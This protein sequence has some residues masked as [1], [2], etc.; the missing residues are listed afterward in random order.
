MEKKMIEIELLSYNDIIKTVSNREGLV[1]CGTGGDLQ[2]WVTGV[3][4]YLY[5]KKAILS[6]NPGDI[7]DRVVVFDTTSAKLKRTDMLFLFQESGKN[8][9]I[10]KL[11]IVRL[12]MNDEITRT[13]WLSDYINNFA[14]DHR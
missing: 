7:W 13:S 9:D 2:D 8:I 11:A 10:G 6:K 14:S 3:T 5:D 1:L 4:E 12:N